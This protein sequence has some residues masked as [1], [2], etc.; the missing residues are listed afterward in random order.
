MPFLIGTDEAGY[1]PNLGPLVISATVWEV[2]D[3]CADDRLYK[4]LRK[5][6][7]NCADRANAKRV[8][9]A[10]SKAIYSPAIG[11]SVLERGVL[12][13]LALCARTPADW[14]QL[15]HALDPHLAG[16]LDALPWHIGFNSPLPLA[17]AL[18]DLESLV[19]AVN[20]GL[21]KAGVRLLAV[22]SRA[23]F[24]ERFNHLAESHGNKAELLSR[25]TLELIAAAMAQLPS[26]PRRPVRVICDRH[27]GRARYRSLLQQQFADNLVQVCQESATESTYT[28]GTAE[29]RVDVRF[30]VQGETY[31][32][33]AVASMASKYLREAA[34]LAFN[35]FWCAK[36]PELRPTA[37]YPLDA[38]R[39]KTEIEP[40]QRALGLHDRM[41]WRNC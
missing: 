11:L 18:E 39:F 25:S 3:D 13:A 31:L 10:D 6:V 9:W 22:Y 2:A 8:A 30:Q 32:P 34:M 4:P 27:G 37:G 23:V 29:N 7:C 41:L 17:T 19:P 40:A 26:E 38:R 20:A 16:E 36:V 12:A 33:V 28:W 15:W 14:R 35:R 21:A 5:V 24:P 1:A